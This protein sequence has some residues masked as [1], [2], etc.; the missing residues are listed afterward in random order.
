LLFSGIS[1]PMDLDF[2]VIL[3]YLLFLRSFLWKCIN[4]HQILS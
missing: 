2:L 1:L 3:I 4:W